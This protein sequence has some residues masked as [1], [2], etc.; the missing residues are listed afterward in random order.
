[1]ALKIGIVRDVRYLEHKT[2]LVHPETPN[3]L[4][5]LYRM[6][7][8]D[9]AGK[10]INIEPEPA[11][12]EQLE[13]V[14]TPAYVNQ[15]LST[16]GR[17][18]TTLAP[19]TTVS[20]ETYMAA[21]LAVGGCIKA[22]ELVL[23]GECRAC[24]AM[25]RPPGHHA[26]PDRAGGFCIF[27]NLG[28]TAKYAIERRGIKRVLIVDWDIHHGNALQDLFYCDNRVLYMSSH[29]MGWYPHTGDW[30]ETGS[31]DG[32]GY[33]V[34]LPVPK[35]LEDN[36]ILHIYRD[37]LTPIVR[38]FR[39]QLILVAAGFDAHQRDPLGRTRLSEKAYYWLTQLVLQL[40][41]ASRSAPLLFSLE[42]GYDLW[43]LAHSVREVLNVL[44]FEG[45]RSRIPVVSTRR[46]REVVDKARQ[47]HAKYGIWTS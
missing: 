43:A 39:P 19:D 33:N 8:K 22:L 35:E 27:D 14:H 32:T 1:L 30:E 31:G 3:R 9:F 2:G 37:V 38:R 7:D 21:W 12:L 29:Y 28:V 46:G 36:D 47:V 6:L 5:S 16:A 45:R 11:T 4:R 26:L 41:E 25:V 20:A 40:A 18:F 34:N 42:G 10:V 17:D 23:S 44:T 13:L 15:I 24:F